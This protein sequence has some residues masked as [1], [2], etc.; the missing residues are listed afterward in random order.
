LISKNLEQ[1]VKFT[2]GTKVQNSPFFLGFKNTIFF[3]PLGVTKNNSNGTHTKDFGEN[4]AP[5]IE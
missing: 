3:S 5:K 2:L 1:L 4:N